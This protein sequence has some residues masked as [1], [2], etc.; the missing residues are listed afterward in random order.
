MVDLFLLGI[1]ALFTAGL[2]AII[3]GLGDLFW[4]QVPIW[5]ASSFVTL[6]LLRKRFR[7]LFKG[8]EV[9]PVRDAES[10][11]EVLVIETVSP[12]KPGRISFKGTSWT[13]TSLDEEIPA[14]SKA[15][16]LEQDGMSFVVASRLLGDGDKPKLDTTERS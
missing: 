13:A 15:F 12:G 6:V 7:K 5:V 1:A 10:G 4:L 8:D 16:I 14:G 2:T 11:R 9:K 3:P